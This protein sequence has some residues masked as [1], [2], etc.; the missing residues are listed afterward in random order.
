MP[1]VDVTYAGPPTTT[2]QVLGGGAAFAAALAD[3]V[4]PQLPGTDVI[5]VDR[6]GTWLLETWLRRH[7]LAG[8]SGSEA[9]REVVRIASA[10]SDDRVAVLHD[11][12][13]D[14]I[15]VS[16]RL[17]FDDSMSA[18]RVHGWLRERRFVS[19]RQELDVF[20]LTT[21]D[22]HWHPQLAPTLA[23]G[24]RG[25]E[26]MAEPNAGQASFVGCFERR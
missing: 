25:V 26:A 16:W 17:R 13:R 5:G 6:L 20:A 21:D 3:D 4:I 19:W 7:G 12:A 11:P 8:Q 23:F 1:L 18:A 22:A 2:R 14:A 15:V 24:P 10:L 9:D